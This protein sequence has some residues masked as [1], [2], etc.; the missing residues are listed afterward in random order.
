MKEVKKFRTK[1]DEKEKIFTKH[2]DRFAPVY[3]L[4]SADT[5]ELEET[6]QKDIY[7]EIQSHAES[8]DI[9]NIMLRYQLGDE[10]VMDKKKGMFIDITMMP[11]SLAEYQDLAMRAEQQFNGLPSEIRAEYDFSA[12]KFIAD[13]GSEKWLK[14]MN[15][16][17]EQVIE[18]ITE[19]EVKDE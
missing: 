10:S 11:K 5:L 17:K 12:E 9:K 1:Y 13:I 18:K 15:P 16:D 4:K 3:T 2:G 8:V 6:G 19:T 14:L 7:S